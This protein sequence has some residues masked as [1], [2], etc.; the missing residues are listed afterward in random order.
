MAI[1]GAIEKYNINNFTLYILETFSTQ[2]YLNLSERE[3]Y[4]Y[5]IIKPSYNI[6]TI[7]QPFSGSNHYRFGKSVPDTVKLK[8]SNTLKGRIVSEKIRSNHILGAKKK[9]V[10]CYEFET[11]KFL[12]MYSGLRIAA[13]ALNLKD[14]F[15]IRYRLDK[16]KPLQVEIENI[17]YNVLFKSNKNSDDKN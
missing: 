3:N 17:K 5:D 2:N 14:S 15:T 10:Y 16:N 11:G 4:W 6:Q 7:L 9:A 1:C 13:R 12:M 8:I